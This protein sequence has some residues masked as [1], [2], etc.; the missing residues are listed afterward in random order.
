MHIHP[1]HAPATIA[2]QGYGVEMQ[3][4]GEHGAI[5]GTWLTGFGP[6][7]L[8]LIALFPNQ[9]ERMVILDYT[10]EKGRK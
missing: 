3:F 1:T 10:A 8:G 9:R 4:T 7:M 6:A 2:F 5:G